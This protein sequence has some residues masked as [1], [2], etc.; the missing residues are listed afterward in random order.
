[1]FSRCPKKCRFF[2]NVFVMGFV[3]FIAG[4]VFVFLGFRHKK[5]TVARE[6][7]W[8]TVR[9]K[10]VEIRT[11]RNWG[12]RKIYT[13]IVLFFDGRGHQT[14]FSQPGSQLP[15][16]SQGQEVAVIYN[17]QNPLQAEIKGST[18][19]HLTRIVYFGVGI[20]GMLFGAFFFVFELIFLLLR[21]SK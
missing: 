20:L 12:G 21:L 13:P 19:S 7:A 2:A 3:I 18:G 14:Y 8:I 16:Y 1:M 17:P 11:H 15:Y 9:G 6:S 5:N 10:I 4:I